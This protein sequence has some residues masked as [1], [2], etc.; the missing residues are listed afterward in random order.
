[1]GE[2][3][4]GRMGEKEIRA[5][6]CLLAR[7]PNPPKGGLISAPDLPPFRGAGGQKTE[8]QNVN[9]PAP[10]RRTMFK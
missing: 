5:G 7:T 10:F 2:W 4:N 3:E 6:N 1:M 8:G 9:N